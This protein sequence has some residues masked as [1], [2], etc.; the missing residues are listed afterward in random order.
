VNPRPIIDVLNSSTARWNY[1]SQNGSILALFLH[2]IMNIHL[3]H[4]DH[5]ALDYLKNTKELLI[6]LPITKELDSSAVVAAV[7]RLEDDDR[8]RLWQI[9]NHCRVLPSL[10]IAYDYNRFFKKRTS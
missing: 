6:L 2:C 4:S 5:W 7:Y 1:R 10:V 3:R 9:T 8:I